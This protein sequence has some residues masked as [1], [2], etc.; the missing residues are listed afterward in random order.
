M[1]RISGKQKPVDDKSGKVP[2][3]MKASTN[4]KREEKKTDVKQKTDKEILD[5]E[6]ADRYG[7][8]YLVLC[9]MLCCPCYCSK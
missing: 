3:Q 7:V 6:N 1:H 2:V 9:N 8:T 5:R 4:L